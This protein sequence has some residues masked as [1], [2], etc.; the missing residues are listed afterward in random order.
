MTYKIKVTSSFKKEVKLAAK[1]KFDLSLLDKVV[2]LL[3]AG[4][5]LPPE[6]KDHELHGNFTG[7]RDCHILPDWILI[8]HYDNENLYL[9]L[10]R[11]GTHSDLFNKNKR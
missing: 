1:R 7:Y 2:E 10:A 9:Y 4:K 8:Y 6:Y 11:T 3:A 5:K